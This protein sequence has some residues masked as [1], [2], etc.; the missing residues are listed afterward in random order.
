VYLP[1]ATFTGLI[2][3]ATAIA[4]PVAWYGMNQWLSGFAY[5][6]AIEWTIFAVAF[7]LALVIASL[8]VSVESIK[9]A[10]AN[11]VTSLRSE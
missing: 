5:H 10:A 7:A 4:I 3:I 6:M 8:T 9:A 11:P 1:S 2:L